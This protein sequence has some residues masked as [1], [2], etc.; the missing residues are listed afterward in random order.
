[1]MLASACSHCARVRVAVMLAACFCERVNLL[2]LAHACG[3][4]MLVSVHVARIFIVVPILCPFHDMVCAKTRLVVQ[5][6]WPSSHV[7]TM[8]GWLKTLLS[9][10]SQGLPSKLCALPVSTRTSWH[11]LASALQFPCCLC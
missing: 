11:H 7:C 6:L 8:D 4:G 1:M 9:M 10:C 3:S 5:T 2:V